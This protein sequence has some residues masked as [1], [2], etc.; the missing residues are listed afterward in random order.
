MYIKT[1][2]LFCAKRDVGNFT[3]Y[4]EKNHR[5]R[6]S[7]ALV[8]FFSALH[9]QA[10]KLVWSSRGEWSWGERS[11]HDLLLLLLHRRRRRCVFFLLFLFHC[12]LTWRK[13]RMFAFVC[14]SICLCCLLRNQRQNRNWNKFWITSSFHSSTFT[15]VYAMATYVRTYVCL[16][17]KRKEEWTLSH[18]ICALLL[19][20]QYKL[21]KF[22]T[23][24]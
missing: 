22:K 6:V 19:L 24:I 7:S 12:S 16:E 5:G 3:N 21:C 18:T 23:E 11:P 1:V 9:M 17:S 4:M 2:L 20:Y 10:R 13:R 14:L 8:L 15:H